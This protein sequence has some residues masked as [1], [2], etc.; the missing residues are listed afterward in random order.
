MCT[1]SCE[2]VAPFGAPSG[3]LLRRRA[4]LCGVVAYDGRRQ[5][6]SW[7]A[8]RI[9][10]RAEPRRRPGAWPA[11]HARGRRSVPHEPAQPVRV[12]H[13]N[14]Q[15]EVYNPIGILS[16]GNLWATMAR[17]SKRNAPEAKKNSNSFARCV[18]QRADGG[19][20]HRGDR[21][22]YRRCAR[23]AASLVMAVPI[24]FAMYAI[25]LASGGSGTCP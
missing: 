11:R 24:N 20:A 18:I 9:G 22:R 7:Q 1:P 15:P 5:P 25:A 19:F 17:E 21:W 3:V 4:A 14:G 12:P 6:S 2:G 10:R 13:G 8:A 23:H 16:R